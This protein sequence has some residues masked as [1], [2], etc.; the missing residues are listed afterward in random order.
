MK[1]DVSNN[2]IYN[3]PK[4]WKISKFCMV[5]EELNQDYRV[6]IKTVFGKYEDINDNN[7]MVCSKNKRYETIYISWRGWAQIPPTTSRGTD[8]YRKG[9][10]S[11]S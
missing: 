6:A 1:D 2:I 11:S 10:I 8:S 9:R 5:G 7:V 3:S 4:P